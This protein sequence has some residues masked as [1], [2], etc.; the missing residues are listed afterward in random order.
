MFTIRQS[1]LDRLSEAA[2]SGKDE[3]MVKYLRERFPRE[4]QAVPDSR[5]LQVVSI[6][7]KIGSR[8]KID[9]ERDI[10]TLADFVVMYGVNFHEDAWAC[11]VLDND[12]LHGPDKVTLLRHR[13][14]A[15]GVDL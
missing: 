6:T 9:H 8:Y 2:S 7:R 13:V 15:T 4:S 3:R 14:R 11:D 12:V 10:A 1:V 5:V